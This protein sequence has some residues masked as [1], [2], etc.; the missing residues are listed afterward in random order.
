[1]NANNPSS[2]PAGGPPPFPRGF[3]RPRTLVCALTGPVL[4]IVLGVLFAVEYN[5]GP[6]FGRTWPVILIVFGAMRLFNYMGSR[7]EDGTPGEP[8]PP[9]PGDPRL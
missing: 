2:Y 1:M 3:G 5:G 8:G 4:M 9:R 6:R 7:S